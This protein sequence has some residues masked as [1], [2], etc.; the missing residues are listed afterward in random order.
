MTVGIHDIRVLNFAV[1][2]IIGTIIIILIL[3]HYLKH[4]KYSL[5]M[6]FV[7]IFVFAII[8]HYILKIDTTLNYILGL[9]NKPIRYRNNYKFIDIISD[10]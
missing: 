3:H 6:L 4:K 5:W 7:G 8:I 2:D 1:L 9:S 10:K